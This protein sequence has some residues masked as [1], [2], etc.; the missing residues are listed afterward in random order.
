MNIKIGPFTIEGSIL[1]DGSYR[2]S[3]G[4]IA[5]AIGKTS[6]DALEFFNKQS[7]DVSSGVCLEA[8]T[9]FWLW[10]ISQGDP[11]ALVIC[12]ALAIEPLERQLDSVF[13]IKRDESNRQSRFS[14][15]LDLMFQHLNNR[16]SIFT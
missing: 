14:K 6:Y 1:P 11:K 4:D 12:Q 5:H 10:S 3:L 8:A 7:E 2:M 13:G 9:S 15:R 16:L